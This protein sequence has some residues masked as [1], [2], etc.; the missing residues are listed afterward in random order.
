MESS[1]QIILLLLGFVI[2]LFT[3]IV[4]GILIQR[5]QATPRAKPPQVAKADDQYG[6]VSPED[7]HTLPTEEYEDDYQICPICG[8]PNPPEY[9]FCKH[10]NGRLH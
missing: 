8:Q 3:G 5:Y 2:G 6:T 7:I 1:Q 10:C 4:V 9:R